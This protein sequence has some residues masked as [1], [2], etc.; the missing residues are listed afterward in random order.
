MTASLK[1]VCPLRDESRADGARSRSGRSTDLDG[2]HRPLWRCRHDVEAWSSS[3][4]DRFGLRASRRCTVSLGRGLDGGGLATVGAANTR[5][6]GRMQLQVLDFLYR[7]EEVARLGGKPVDLVGL[8]EIAGEGASRSR[9]ESIRRAT[10]S[11]ADEG[12]VTLSPP[13]ALRT[14]SPHGGGFV[15]PLHEVTARLASYPDG[16]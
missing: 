16:R 9:V 6:H 3:C 5:S 14:R 12:L 2:P 7:S 4:P 1:G 10:R 8:T 13:V 15:R 11:L